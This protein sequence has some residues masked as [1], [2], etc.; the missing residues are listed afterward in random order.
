MNALLTYGKIS[1]RPLEPED[2]DLLYQWENNI[3]IWQVSNTKAPFSKHILAQYLAESAK[4]IYA[5][6]QLRLIIQDENMHAV[7]A[8]D[9]FDFEPYHL[10]AGVGI[11]IHQTEDRGKG[12]AHDAL[13]ALSVYALE[14]LGLKQLYANI[15]VDNAVSI[16][17][18]EKAGF[19][20]SGIKKDWLKTR[21]GWKDEI[22]FQKLLC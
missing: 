8:V 6:R 3:E 13:L 16:H 18:F 17:L 20:Q 2:I 7:G 5:T 9:L 4:D 15:A 19:Q 10:R 22:L 11:L 1:L 14:V 21:N 12:Y